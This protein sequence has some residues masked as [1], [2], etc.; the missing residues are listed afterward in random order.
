MAEYEAGEHGTPSLAVEHFEKVAEASKE[1]DIY[2]KN[3]Y[4]GQ[5]DAHI[6]MMEQ[7]RIDEYSPAEAMK[8]AKRITSSRDS[9]P[10]RSKRFQTKELEP[11]SES[12]SESESASVDED[13][14]GSESQSESGASG[15][16]EIGSRRRRR[17]RRGSV[18]KDKEVRT[19]TGKGRM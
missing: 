9:V 5:S 6:A 1:F 4:G 17:E 19:S 18:R 14:S 8:T 10:T 2:L 12:E 7:S 16:S 3:V 13:A 15:E 11:D